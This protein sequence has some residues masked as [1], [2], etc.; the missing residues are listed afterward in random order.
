[1][2]SINEEVAVD[3]SQSDGTIPR[4]GAVSHPQVLITRFHAIARASVAYI[5]P[6]CVGPHWGGMWGNVGIDFGGETSVVVGLWPFSDA[7]TAFL[8]VCPSL[9]VVAS[10]EAVIPPQI[11]SELMARVLAA[12]GCYSQRR[13][14]LLRGPV[15]THRYRTS[16]R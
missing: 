1:M 3:G 14:V 10:T 4:G 8:G 9:V 2:C 7:K 16:G 15:L 5:P 11:P 6:Y 12:R 13:T